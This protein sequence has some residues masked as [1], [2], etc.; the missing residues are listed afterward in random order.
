MESHK[1]NNL[2]GTDDDY[3]SFQTRELYIINDQNN[4]QCDENTTIKFTTEVI[5][6]NLCDFGD[7]YV[8]VTGSVKIISGAANT[9]IC[10]KGLSLFTRSVLHLNGTHVETAEN[11]TLVMKHYNLIEYSKNYQATVLCINLKEMS[12]H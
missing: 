11:L 7:A 6:S 1:I 12:N 9:K 4:G 10:F 3:K 8:L 2:L 5:K